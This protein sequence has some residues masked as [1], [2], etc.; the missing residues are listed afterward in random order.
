MSALLQDLTT[1]EGL[2]M[3]GWIQQS[4][5]DLKKYLISLPLLTKPKIGKT[6][7]LY[8]ATFTKMVSSVL[9]RE[10]ENQIQWSIYYT[11]K[12][13]HN[14]K[15]RYSKAE[16][17]IYALI[18]STQRLQSYFQIY[19][20]VVLTDQPLMI[21]LYLLDIFDW[22]AKWVIKFSEFDNRYRLWPSMKVQVLADFIIE[23]TV[24]D[25]RSDNK[26]DDK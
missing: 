15:I 21:I 18:I 22:M 11:S 19:S 25:D 2:L 9:V 10:D 24:S 4:F 20:I 7:Y 17:M 1:N 12:V 6:L 23:C 14:A 13:L 3:V 26:S 16:K 5:K 8:L